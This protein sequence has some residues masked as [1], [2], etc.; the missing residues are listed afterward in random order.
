M[1]RDPFNNH[2]RSP[3][4]R[5]RAERQA[6]HA[7]IALVRTA[8]HELRAEGTTAGGVPFIALLVWPNHVYVIERATGRLI[9]CGVIGY[10]GST[11]VAQGMH[12]GH[13]APAQPEACGDSD[14]SDLDAT[15]SNAV[16][17]LRCQWSP[18]NVRGTLPDGRKVLACMHWPGAVHVLSDPGGQLLGGG[19]FVPAGAP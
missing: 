1:N 11:I 2:R 10:D 15:F 7:G 4:A 14:D 16:E 8:W 6:F 12:W 3:K 19:A 13:C 17:R 18:I 5:R 9:T